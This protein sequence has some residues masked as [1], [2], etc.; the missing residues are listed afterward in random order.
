MFSQPPHPSLQSIKP[1]T[2]ATLNGACQ[3]NGLK[4]PSI[5]IDNTLNLQYDLLLG[6]N[7]L[8]DLGIAYTSISVRYQGGLPVGPTDA[9]SCSTVGDVANLVYRRA[10]GISF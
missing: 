8:T 9:G 7:L 2:D 4:P 1:Q 6:P 3:N 5:P 10:N